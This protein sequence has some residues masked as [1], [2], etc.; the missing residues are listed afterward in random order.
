MKTFEWLI[1]NHSFWCLTF[2]TFIATIKPSIFSPNPAGFPLEVLR[3]GSF[4][5]TVISTVTAIVLIANCVISLMATLLSRYML[6]FTHGNLT[7]F[8]NLKFFVIFAVIPSTFGYAILFF[9]FIVLSKINNKTDKQ[10]AAEFSSYLAEPALTLKGFFYTPFEMV[11]I[12]IFVFFVS[13]ILCCICG[14]IFM[15][16]FFYL[17][18]SNNT[19]TF[20][21]S[22]I[23]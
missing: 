17:I 6:A 7:K 10:R 11:M 21:T 15:V 13:L 9:T 22:Q 16:Y 3:N 4:Q 20:Q 18:K 23:Y 12:G 5:T 8:C 14:V 19:Q 2:E 1:L